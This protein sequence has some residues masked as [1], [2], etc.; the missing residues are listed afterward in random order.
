MREDSSNSIREALKSA[1]REGK[2]PDETSYRKLSLEAEQALAAKFSCSMKDIEIIALENNIIPE[3]YQRSLGTVGGEQGQLRLLKSCVGVVGLGGLGGLAGELLA[4]MGVGSLV[5][6]DGDTYSESNLNR[7]LLSSQENL[8]Q[9]KAAVARE[10]IKQVNSA[11]EMK[12]YEEYITKSNVDDLIDSCQ[13]VVDCLDNLKTRFLLQESCARKNAALVHGAIAQFYGQVT[14]ILPGDKGLL[15]IYGA[16]KEEM[17]K[18]IEK[19]LGN[20]AT[21]PAL[22]ASL[23]VQEVLKVLLNKGTLLRN[24]L[25]YIDTLDGNCEQVQLAFENDK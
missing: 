17:N 11:V 12:V 25:L 7:Q 20:P 24:R 9:K 3:R 18:G 1:V 4:R 8:G 19:Q 16:Y 15:A 21:T 2:A 23:Q 13:V 5:L 14:T 10:R 6:V 22:V